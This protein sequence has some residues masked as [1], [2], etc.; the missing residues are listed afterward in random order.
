ME[1]ME[2]I[3]FFFIILKVSFVHSNFAHNVVCYCKN[4]FYVY[5]PNTHLYCSSYD[6]DALIQGYE[7]RDPPCSGSCF[8]YRCQ[9]EEYTLSEYTG[10]LSGHYSDYYYPTKSEC[11]NE[12]P[13]FIDDNIKINRFCEV[14]YIVC[15]EGEI[16]QP[17]NTNIEYEISNLN[18][19]NEQINTALN[20]ECFTPTGND[21]SWY[22]DCVAKRYDC[23]EVKKIPF[24]G[25]ISGSNDF[26]PYSET[27]NYAI[28]YGEKFCKLYEENYASFSIKGKIW[29]DKVRKCLQLKLV[30]YI[31]PGSDVTC[32]ELEKIAFESHTPCYLE[33]DGYRLSGICKLELKDWIQVFFTI[34]SAFF[35]Q[36][37]ES[38]KGFFEVCIQ[39]CG[40]NL[41]DIYDDETLALLGYISNPNGVMK[42]RSIKHNNYS[43]TQRIENSLLSLLKPYQVDIFVYINETQ[44]S[45][46]NMSFVVLINLA[47]QLFWV[48]RENWNS[49]KSRLE[50]II[51]NKKLFLSLKSNGTVSLYDQIMCKLN[52][53]C[54]S[55]PN[56]LT[57]NILKY[58][59]KNYNKIF[60]NDSKKDYVEKHARF[61]RKHF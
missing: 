3:I 29:V 21:C 18:E 14:E 41:L 15:Y 39:G 5:R 53:D 47:K 19:K 37:S 42:K 59:S 56:I 61:W 31:K 58:D 48:N 45:N 2:K 11:F 20:D 40:M 7:L 52:Q 13:K 8:D 1:M 10:K 17:V 51:L 33:P 55:N 57:Y 16:V 6:L 36:F 26:T 38:V 30:D 32:E 12:C 4:N 46:T 60:D 24:H 43:M 23:S 44:S 34:K 35:D 28:D 9:I 50:E 54:R 25:I 27:H 49:E 22:R